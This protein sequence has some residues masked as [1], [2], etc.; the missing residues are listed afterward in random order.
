[1]PVQQQNLV[2]T[3][4]R[5]FVGPRDISRAFT[6]ADCKNAN[7]M[8]FLE[9]YGVGFDSDDLEAMADNYGFAMDAAIQGLTTTPSIDVPVQFLQQWLPGFVNI[10]FRARKIDELIGIS[11]QGAWFDSEI[12]QG[13]METTGSAVPYGDYTNTPFADWNVNFIKRNIVNFETGMRVGNKEQAQATR[14][15]LNTADSKRGGA[16]NAL[17][18]Q[19]NA[20]GFYGYNAGNNL[21]YGFLNDPQLLG[22]NT[23]AAT[24]TGST[25]TWATKT[26]LEIQS[27]LL[28][29]IAGLRTQSG[30][31]IDPKKDKITLAIATNCIDYLGVTSDFGSMASV[32]AWLTD[33]CKNIRIVDAPE[34][35]NANGGQNVFYLYAE[36]VADG[37]T[38][39]ERTWVQVVPSKF[40][41]NGVAQL[42][43]AY[44][45]SYLN[46]TAGALLKRP[47]AVY[48]ATGI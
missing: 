27:D 29:A 18:I 35:D 2:E 44:E 13:V 33:Y 31:N 24:G 26:F 4:E 32:N 37:S 1:M 10:I 38:D 36:S 41:L 28:T 23:V 19:R 43:K 47:Y 16:T 34:L 6:K 21:T 8:D 46:A 7:V 39:D 12:V 42:A 48:R 14:I 11:T 9:N 30:A 5:G 40:Q 45:E 15:R 20:I 25:T 3:F 17:E 22:Y